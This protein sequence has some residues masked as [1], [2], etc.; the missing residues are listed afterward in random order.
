MLA[1][2]TDEKLAA[3]VEW[4]KLEIE[5]QT[6]ERERQHSAILDP[7]TLAD[8]ALRARVL[9][10]GPLSPSLQERYDRLVTERQLSESPAAPAPTPRGQPEA[11]GSQT[12]GSVRTET[13]EA[14]HTKHNYA[15]W[16]VKLLDRVD[17]G[18]FKGLR[19]I[20]RKHDGYYSSYTRDGAIPGFVFKSAESARGFTDTISPEQAPKAPVEPLTDPSPEATAEAVEEPAA[21]PP[22]ASSP[23]AATKASQSLLKQAESLKAKA[24]EAL[25]VDRKVNTAKRAR[26]AGYAE[27]AAHKLLTLAATMKRIAE[28]N[29]DGTI[30]VLA[31]VRERTHVELLEQVFQQGMGAAKRAASSEEVSVA[32]GIAAASWPRF[33]VFG[34]DMPIAELRRKPGTE[35]LCRELET[36]SQRATQQAVWIYAPLEVVETVWKK[37]G[38][39]AAS[40]VPHTWLTEHTKLRRLS[41]MGIKS[42]EMLREALRAYVLLRAERSTVDPV[43]EAMRNLAGRKVGIDFFPTPPDVARRMVEMADV[44]PGDNALEPQGGAAAIAEALREAG[45]EPDVCEIS[46]ELRNILQLKGFN[47]VGDD[48]L[49][50]MP[51]ERY[52]VIVANPPFGKNADMRHTRHAFELLAPGG[53]L[54]TIIGEG[55]FVRKGFEETA[56]RQWMEALDAEIEELPQGTFLDPALLA[57]TGANARI[58]KIIRPRA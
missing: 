14:K 45:I 46:S 24:E 21:E 16:V 34:G 23:P 29:H 3:N 17:D 19:D 30:K 39:Q 32:E 11:T 48:F 5:R 26:E 8:F 40:V 37:L 51:E 53:R 22:A 50:Y 56:F 10:K 43:K 1:A 25:S 54:V 6:A 58:V 13:V 28:A 36:L 41:A 42:I 52:Q 55:A 27:A 12:A 47:V 7:Q 4:R 57:T 2:L 49:A 20:A 31:C 18:I 9:G 15:I 44:Q 38:N 35:R 33:R